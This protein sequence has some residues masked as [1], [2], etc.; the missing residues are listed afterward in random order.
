MNLRKFFNF[1]R[2]C[3][4]CLFGIL[5]YTCNAKNCK[6]PKLKKDRTLAFRLDGI[7]NI[8]DL[9]GYKTS[10][11]KT[12]KYSSV[13]ICDP[14]IHLENDKGHDN[15]TDSDI[16][17]LKNK[18][19][20]KT[21][22]DL[23][24]EPF[25]S[26]KKLPK[27]IKYYNIKLNVLLDEKKFSHWLPKSRWE[28]VYGAPSRKAKI[29]QIFDI[30][31]NSKN[32]AVLVNATNNFDKRGLIATLILLLKDVSKSDI[33]DFFGGCSGYPDSIGDCRLVN[34]RPYYISA[35]IDY[36]ENYYENAENYLLKCGVSQKNINK[37]KNK[38]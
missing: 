7:E 3:L 14:A 17:K 12:T 25:I 35:F 26:S 34:T 38:L 33:E 31:A 23:D 16:I 18:F 11:G 21:I 6:I 8:K 29:K 30:I 37:I 10:S 20:L 1:V 9:G 2:V 27:G 24:E 28:V 5:G 19:N 22:I 15:L 36:I 13:L 32:G 4:I